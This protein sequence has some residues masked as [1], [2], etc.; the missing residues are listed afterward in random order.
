MTGKIKLSHSIA[1]IVL[2]IMAV[3]DI[4]PFIWMFLCSFKTRGE[5]LSF[6]PTFWP[7]EWRFQNYSDA[8]NAGG[9][10]FTNMFINTLLIAIPATF[11]TVLSSSLA[12]YGFARI[13]FRGREA[14]FI[15]F[16]ISMMIPDAVTLIPTFLIFKNIG[17]L[18][19][20]WAI[21]IPQFFGFALQI[22]LIRQFFMTIPRDMEDAAVID[23]CNRF[24]IYYKVFIPLSKPVITAATVFTFQ[25]AYNDFLKPLIF[26]NDTGKFT[27]QLGLATF[28]GMY[29]TQ[30]DLLMAASFFTLLPI[31]ILYIFAQKYFVEGI[32]TTGIKG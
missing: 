2:T 14:I 1:Y 6:P 26:L 11:F 10:N 3:V 32:V 22:F 13:K 9:L 27:V 20:L 19:T 30:Y 5:I 25:F 24:K 21:L 7:T 31:L 12:A 16:L 29:R 28:R 17:L 8:W 15:V 23:G 4:V 18:N